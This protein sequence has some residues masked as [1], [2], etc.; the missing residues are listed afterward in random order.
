MKA[1]MAASDTMKALSTMPTMAGED[2]ED[3]AEVA[4]EFSAE[5][6]L[7]DEI[8]LVSVD[9]EDTEDDSRLPGVVYFEEAEERII[10]R[11]ENIQLSHLQRTHQ[12]PGT[13]QYHPDFGVTVK[14][15]WRS[16][17][18][19]QMTALFVRIEYRI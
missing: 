11:Y 7:V 6:G 9:D 12:A 14:T 16:L 4:D 2:K 18:A 10:E 3:R 13:R 1:T 5:V 17:Y 19:D 8:G 15:I